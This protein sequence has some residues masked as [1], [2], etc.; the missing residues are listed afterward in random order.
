MLT[1]KE[2]E[3]L[4]SYDS[5]NSEGTTIG[6]GHEWNEEEKGDE[7]SI[8]KLSAKQNKKKSIG[9]ENEVPDQ[10]IKKINKPGIQNF[11]LKNSKKRHHEE[12]TE[13]L[14]AYQEEYSTCSDSE[15]SNMLQ[16]STKEESVQEKKPHLGKVRGGQVLGDSNR[17]MQN[18]GEWGHITSQA[19]SKKSKGREKKLKRMKT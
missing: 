17:T 2:E 14:L 10:S 11:R 6:I 12:E 19:V 8:I 5:S 18:A 13:S 3:T 7:N 4:S 9:K 15:D 1:H 16:G